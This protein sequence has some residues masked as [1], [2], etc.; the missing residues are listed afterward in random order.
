MSVPHL[1]QVDALSNASQNVEPV[2]R[3]RQAGHRPGADDLLLELV[4]GAQRQQQPFSE[5]GNL[6]R[7]GETRAWLS[8]DWHRAEEAA[9][10]ASSALTLESGGSVQRGAEEENDGEARSLGLHK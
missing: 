2:G 8:P 4:L 10:A 9:L 1:P 7:E 6:G 5:G 3:R